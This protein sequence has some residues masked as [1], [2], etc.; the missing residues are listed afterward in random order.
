MNKSWQGS[1][2][3]VLTT[4]NDALK[5][6]KMQL[7]SLIKTNQAP[8]LLYPLAGPGKWN[9]GLAQLHCWEGFYTRGKLSIVSCVVFDRFVFLICCITMRSKVIKGYI[10]LLFTAMED[11]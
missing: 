10:S 2:V 4:A 11:I 5:G 3:R 7:S 1:F 8:C 9:P 6:E